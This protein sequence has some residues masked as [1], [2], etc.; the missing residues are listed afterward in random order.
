MIPVDDPLV[1]E[2]PRLRWILYALGAFFVAGLAASTT[3]AL[4]AGG[5]GFL[6]L[7][8]LIVILGVAFALMARSPGR[9]RI[10]KDGFAYTALLRNG[11]YRWSDV[12]R[13]GVYLAVGGQNVGFDL[14]PE[15][16]GSRPRRLTADARGGFAASLPSTYGRDAHALADLLERRRVAARRDPP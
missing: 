12:S 15:Y 6:L 9:L 11:S 10:A 13:F 3:M 8:G 2:A 5:N 4:D 1:L 14:A 7:P 16:D